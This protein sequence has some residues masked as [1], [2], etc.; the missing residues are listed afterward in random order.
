MMMNVSS[1]HAISCIRRA[2]TALLAMQRNPWEQGVAAQA[3]LE[4]GDT[5]VVILMAKEAVHRQDNLGRLATLYSDPGVTDPAA[6]GEAVLYAAQATQDPALKNAAD[7]ML[8]YLLN[9][10]PRTAR[11]TLHHIT[12]KPQVWVDSFYMAPPFLAVAGHP[13]EAIKQIEGFR[14]LLWDANA[15]LYSHIWDEETHSFARKDFWGVGNGWA[16]AGMAR[17]LQALPDT[18]QAERQ[19]LAGYIQ[20][21]LDGCLAHL[22][23]DGLF[24][25]VIDNSDTFIETNLSQMLAYTIYRG[26]KGGWLSPAF[27]SYAEKMRAAAYQ[28]V[29]EY[30]LVQGVCSSP[31][32]DRPGVAPEG[33]A[34]FLLMEAAYQALND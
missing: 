23:P 3:F 2:K 20:E 8:D 31:S 30:G 14:Q 29:D 32:F 4:S 12:T 27:R 28:K 34:F 13:Q 11:G 7:R 6:N 33:Q 16:A 19:R 26:I 24:H 15:R 5:D 25:D 1:E 21:L 10:A 9:R 17:V 18:M 22:R